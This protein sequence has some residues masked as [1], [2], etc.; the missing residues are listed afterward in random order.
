[1]KIIN[2]TF[3]AICLLIAT[4]NHSNA[5]TTQSPKVEEQSIKDVK[6]KQIELTDKYTII[7][8]QYVSA[9]SLGN[10]PFRDMPNLQMQGGSIWLDPETRL[11]KPGDINTKFKL[12]KTENIPTQEKR[13]SV[14][15][16]EVVDFVAYFERITP[17]IEV[18]DFYEGRATSPNERTWNFYGIHIKNPK[19]KEKVLEKTTPEKPKEPVIISDPEK[20]VTEKKEEKNVF[21]QLA[22]MVFDAKTKEPVSANIQYTENKDT[23]NLASKAGQFRVGLDLSKNYAFNIN[24]IGYF[25][26]SLVLTPSDSAGTAN[27]EKVFYLNSLRVG[28]SIN[29]PN[30]YFETSS[31]TILKESDTELNKLVTF[32]NNNPNTHIR[33]EGHTDNVGDFDKNLELSRKRAESVKKY[34]V[35]NGILESRILA[36]GFGS[37]KPIAKNNTAEEHGKNRR[38]AF[39]LTEI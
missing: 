30:I 2:H 8:L 10:N 39:V 4:L 34:L 11:Y 22:I 21:G 31:F 27:F 5:Q 14:N 25:G 37:T 9:N 13:M 20:I 3:L 35:E 16:G 12:I 6:I 29:L 36:Q 33:I 18:F 26:E 1:M 38:V 7:Y 19:N 15:R 28:E 17:G 24:A 23:L 32:M